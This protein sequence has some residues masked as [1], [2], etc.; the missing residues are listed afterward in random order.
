MEVTN[1]TA[2]QVSSADMVRELVRMVDGLANQVKRWQETQS[3]AY[4][5]VVKTLEGRVDEIGSELD[6]IASRIKSYD[7]AFEPASKSSLDDT[8]I[9]V[10]EHLAYRVAHLEKWVTQLDD[11]FKKD[12]SLARKQ[13]FISLGMLGAAAAFLI[14]AIWQVLGG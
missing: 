6:S 14:V 10:L 13:F 8:E 3:N 2:G 4:S 7:E 9:P 12:A 11:K 5:E 1:T